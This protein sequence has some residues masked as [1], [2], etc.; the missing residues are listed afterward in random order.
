MNHSEDTFVG[1]GGRSMYYQSW[2]PETSPRGMILVVHGLGEHSA[3]YQC[4]AT[5]FVARDYVVGALD[6][7]GHGYSG[8]S[9][10]YVEAF[11]D[12]EDD[13]ALFHELMSQ[14]FP[15][16]PAFLLGHS[17][18]GLISC[19]YL[20]SAQ[21][22]FSG[23]MLSGA[24]V[25]TSQQPGAIGMW[26]IRLLSR[27]IPRLGLSRLDAK[28]V[29]RDADEVTKYTEDPLV[30]HG[31]LSARL[32][33]EFFGSMQSLRASAGEIHIPLLI[34]HGSEDVMVA[35]EGSQ[36]L[37]ER[38]GSDD[39]TLV[40]YPGLYHEIFNEPEKDRVFGD[41]LA[42]LERHLEPSRQGVD[43]GID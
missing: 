9:P 4:L 33:H 22:R 43:T 19:C 37:H 39:K 7:N 20:R 5:Y 11:S 1:A 29:S 41:M 30:Y 24:A 12:Y 3:R 25:I 18:G 38:V 32:L 40:L 27:V 2:A 23:A 31:A 35:P 16:I 26:L 15:Q 8:G 34:M 10:G 17:M 6:L 13:L 21:D 42:W 36:L 14:R 28:G